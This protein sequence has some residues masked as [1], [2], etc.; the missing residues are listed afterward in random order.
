MHHGSNPAEN[1]PK[2]INEELLK[3]LEVATKQFELGATGKAPQGFLNPTDEGELKLAIG[4]EQNKVVINF[5]KPVA[6]IGFDWK[7][8]L[9][10]AELIRKKAHE[11]RKG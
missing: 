11:I 4:I 1:T 7:Q 10:L 6:W 9:E 2:P 8:A 5:G 3:K